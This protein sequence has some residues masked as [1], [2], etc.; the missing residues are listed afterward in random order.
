[1]KA[2]EKRIDKRVTVKLTAHQLQKL[3]TSV[4]ESNTTLSKYIR[5][6]LKLK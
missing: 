4:Q 6:R 1:M 5:Q 2:K 3:K